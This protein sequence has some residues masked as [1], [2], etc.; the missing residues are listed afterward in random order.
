MGGE[1]DGDQLD[2]LNRIKEI[3]RNH[4]AHGSFSRE[5]MAYVGIP[6]FGR[7]PMLMG[8]RYLQGF[9]E[10]EQPY[11]VSYELF[12]YIEDA[13]S[14][15]WRMLGERFEIP[16]RFITSGIAI[17]VDTSEYLRN[18]PDAEAAERYIDRLFFMLDNQSN[19]DW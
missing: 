14:A 9:T 12:E 1:P 10:D 17:P 19:M 6:G 3:Y 5:M 11:V 2:D 18:A 7:Y 8:K 16:M 15:F 4:N 13:F